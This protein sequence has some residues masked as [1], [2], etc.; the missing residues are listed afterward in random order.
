[1]EIWRGIYLAGPLEPSTHL[2]HMPLEMKWNDG[3]VGETCLK[4]HTVS[5]KMGLYW[6]LITFTVHRWSA[7]SCDIQ[8]L[9]SRWSMELDHELIEA[10]EDGDLVLALNAGGLL[11]KK[12]INMNGELL[13]FTLKQCKN[14]ERQ[15]WLFD[16]IF[17]SLKIISSI[18]C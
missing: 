4:T 13:S 11:R 12:S 14:N 7:G 5:H 18:Y 10:T 17:Q 3:S 6:V 16:F 2:L 8:T 1:M 15:W 9:T